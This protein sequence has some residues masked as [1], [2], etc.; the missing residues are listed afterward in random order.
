MPKRNKYILTE[1]QAAI[2]NYRDEEQKTSDMIAKPLRRQIRIDNLTGGLV[3]GL[4]IG[5]IVG[6]LAGD[7]RSRTP[8][9]DDNNQI[10]SYNFNENKLADFVLKSITIATATALIIAGIK[11]KFDKKNNK[12]NIEKMA[13]GLMDQYFYMALREFDPIVNAPLK[14]S[15]LVYT[16]ATALI[17]N[18]MPETEL[19][20]IR[21]FISSEIKYAANGQPVISLDDLKPYG[22][23]I[24]TVATII[25][26][27]INHNP[28]LKE[29]VL[30]ILNGDKPKTYFLPINKPI[31]YANLLNQHTK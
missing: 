29:N 11:T 23:T 3:A 28:E 20:R 5:T 13:G 10:V 26:N 27:Y 1:E 7:P 19:N 18:N 12:F 31:T 9:Y 22:K 14:E 2:K 24:D 8:V 15:F 25:S 17:I 4:A 16:R 30:A 21:S 6:A